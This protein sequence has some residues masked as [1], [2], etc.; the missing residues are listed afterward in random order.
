MMNVAASGGYYVALPADYILAHPT[1]VTGSVGVIMMRLEAFDLMKKIG[2]DVKTT[3]S[4][5]KKDMGTP[6]REMTK[7]EGAI[8]QQLSDSLGKR[9]TGLVAQ[10]RKLDSNALAD[11]A[12]ARIYGAEEAVKI[13]LVDDIGYLND[14]IARA[15]IIGG[16]PEDAKIVVYRTKKFPDD[17]LYNT[18]TSQYSGG[19]LSLVNIGL[20]ANM[21]ELHTG[22]YYLWSPG[23][24][25]KE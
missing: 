25:G 6:F 16:L 11:V 22:F 7:E 15:K 1:T 9:F 17:N 3:T 20:F 21:P 19:N 12:T 8:F 23:D 4:G 2:L 5:D 10:H 14:A 18:M 13:G 24:F